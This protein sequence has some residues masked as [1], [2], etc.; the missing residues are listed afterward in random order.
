MV[1]IHW[2]LRST[3]HR[4]SGQLMGSH[5]IADTWRFRETTPSTVA[6]SFSTNQHGDDVNACALAGLGVVLGVG[7]GRAGRAG[8]GWAWGLAMLG[9]LT[10][11]GVVFKVEKYTIEVQ[12]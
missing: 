6:S 5:Q 2:K 11:L 12:K 8:L 7:F 3:G 4:H 10:G 1:K 9:A